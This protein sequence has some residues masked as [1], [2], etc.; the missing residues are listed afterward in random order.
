[1]IYKSPDYVN[2]KVLVDAYEK[3][4]R[5]IAGLRKVMAFPDGDAIEFMVLKCKGLSSNDSPGELR[6]LGL[7]RDAIIGNY[8]LFLIRLYNAYAKKYSINANDL[9]HLPYINFTSLIRNYCPGSGSK[10]NSYMILCLNG[11]IKKYIHDDC[12]VKITPS[13]HISATYSELTIS[14][15]DGDI[16]E[17]LSSPEPFDADIMG[18]IQISDRVAGTLSNDE[19]DMYNYILTTDSIRSAM[20]VYSEQRG[21]CKDSA[22]LVLTRMRRKMKSAW[23]AFSSGEKIRLGGKNVKL[24][25]C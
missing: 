3:S 4:K 22:I 24:A 6:L 15:D 14:E 1:M 2:K 20:E 7:Y 19:R 5:I 13:H 23:K 8:S 21:C 25:Q 16:V 10:F 9:T 17:Y 12:L 18:K 11:Y